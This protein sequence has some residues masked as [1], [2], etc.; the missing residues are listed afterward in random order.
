VSSVI[1]IEHVEDH[2]QSKLDLKHSTDLTL[3][4]GI[5]KDKD[6]TIVIYIKRV[7]NIYDF[8]VLEKKEKKLNKL[9]LENLIVTL[10]IH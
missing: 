10:I 2:W 1:P 5:L 3:L 7:L 6:I 4:K 9:V 8:E